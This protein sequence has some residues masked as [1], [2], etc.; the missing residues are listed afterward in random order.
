[1]IDCGAIFRGVMRLKMTVDNGRVVAVG[2]ILE[3][4]VRL[5]Q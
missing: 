5:R 4:H 1:V 2:R 3:V